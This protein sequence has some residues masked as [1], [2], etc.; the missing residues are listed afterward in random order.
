M[1]PG[2]N[3]G[4]GNLR[5]EEPAHPASGQAEGGCLQDD[6]LSQIANFLL[7]I[8]IIH[9]SNEGNKGGGTLY[10]AIGT[11][12]AL[13]DS[14][15]GL[16]DSAALAEGNGLKSLQRMCSA[17]K[18]LGFTSRPSNRRRDLRKKIASNHPKAGISMEVSFLTQCLMEMH[19]LLM[20]TGSIFGKGI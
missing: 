8:W 13:K 16:G 10:L 12:R 20:S 1:A 2:S 14:C 9:L 15:R 11:D 3:K 5:T 6:T 7:D 17:C 18:T 19:L 4:A